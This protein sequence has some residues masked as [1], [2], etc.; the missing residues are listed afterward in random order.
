MVYLDNYPD[1]SLP[2]RVFE[3]V[4][5]ILSEVNRLGGGTT[6]GECKPGKESDASCL[7]KVK[8]TGRTVNQTCVDGNVIAVVEHLAGRTVYPRLICNSSLEHAHS[9]Y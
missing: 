5:C 9:Q 2:N 6:A 8:A 3:K 7:W 1:N 4:Y